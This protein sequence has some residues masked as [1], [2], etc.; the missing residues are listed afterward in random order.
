MAEATFGKETDGASSSA[1]S[2]DKKDASTATPSTSGTLTKLTARIWLSSAGTAL[3]KGV[4]Y[5]D[6]GGVPDALLATGDE[7][8]LTATSEGAVD[9]PFSGAEQYEL[10]GGTAYWIGWIHNDPGTMSFTWSRA[11]TAAA[12][13]Q[14]ADTY[15]DG[16]S[17]PYGTATG[18]SGP[19][20][21]YGTYTESGG[22]E[23]EGKF[24]TFF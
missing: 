11:A 6:S 19:I 13:Q 2:T 15:S 24:F 23:D 4:L 5:S 1:S 18:L 7:V 8:S 16:P 3:A 10:V 12:N 17:D 20:D 22:A 21:C 9:L 14:I